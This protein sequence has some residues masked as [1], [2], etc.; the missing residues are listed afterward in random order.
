MSKAFVQKPAPHFQG[1]AVGTDGDFKEIKL[2]DYKGRPYDY[3]EVLVVSFYF[4]RTC[5][6][7]GLVHASWL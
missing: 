3:V 2:S 7:L 6:T 1:T 5:P 4:Y